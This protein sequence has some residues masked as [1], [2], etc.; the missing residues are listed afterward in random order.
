M[1]TCALQNFACPMDGELLRREA[2]SL[3]CDRGHTFDF[4]REGYCNLLLVQQKASKDPGPDHLLELRQVIY[5]NVEKSG[6]PSL[7]EAE[8]LG[9][10]L[11]AEECLK[12]SFT[13]LHSREILDLV[14][15]TPH[16]YRLSEKGQAALK[17]LD[18][19]SV[20]A[21]LVFRLLRFQGK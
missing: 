6:P 14:S 18:G 9:Y 13:L 5:P 3:R 21:D 20:S 19:L 7:R 11:E 15:M 16:A 17:Q 12:F 10:R 2:N 8:G 1:Q 4:A